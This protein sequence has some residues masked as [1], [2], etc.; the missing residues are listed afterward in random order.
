MTTCAAASGLL[1]TDG[2][3]H[4][5]LNISIVLHIA[6]NIHFYRSH[7]FLCL[8]QSKSGALFLSVRKAHKQAA[9]NA[10]SFVDMDDYV[11]VK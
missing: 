7:A 2:Q 1:Q 5:T 11:R 4:R 6:P 9:S 3:R 10:L 8:S